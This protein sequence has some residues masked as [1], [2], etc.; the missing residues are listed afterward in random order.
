M[1]M[2]LLPRAAAAAIV[3]AAAGT[4]SSP[5]SASLVQLSTVQLT[6]QGVG[7]NLTALFLQGQGSNTTESG[8]VLFNGTPFGDAGNGASQ[9]HTFT[10][11]DLGITNASQLPHRQLGGTGIREPAFGHHC[12]EPTAHQCKPRQCDYA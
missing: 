3:L 2:Q 10:F 7:A 8:G 9:T 5:A 6:G 12:D 4:L 11:A 1:N